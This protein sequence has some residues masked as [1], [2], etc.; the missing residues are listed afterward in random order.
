LFERQSD[1]LLLID[2]CAAAGAG[3]VSGAKG[4][5]EVEFA[6]GFEAPTPVWGPHSFTRSLVNELE[7]VYD[8]GTTVYGL[9]HN[10]WNTL[11][12]YRPQQNGREMRAKP[13]HEWLAPWPTPQ[14]RSIHLQNLLST[15]PMQLQQ[16]A[17]SQTTSLQRASSFDI[18]KIQAV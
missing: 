10:L 17:S 16:D 2:C 7:K 5:V 14:Y 8:S 12:H 4:L 6:G 15:A 11:Q 13:H 3:V 1:I 18:V 9:H